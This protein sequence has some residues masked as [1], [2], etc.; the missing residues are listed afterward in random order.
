MTAREKEIYRQYQRLNRQGVEIPNTKPVLCTRHGES[1]KLNHRV[2]KTVAASVLSDDG[3]RTHSEVPTDEGNEIDVIG[4]GHPNRKP[5]VI[6]VENS[7][8]EET[9]S[10]KIDQYL[11]GDVREVFVISL[12]E[13]P[14]SPG[15]LYEHIQEQTGLL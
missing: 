2:A 8:D 4:Y 6:E 3:Y 1:E 11:I 12:D 10:K 13:A 7:L 15:E 5:V 9:R 14:D